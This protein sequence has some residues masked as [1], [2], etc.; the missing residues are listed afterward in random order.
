ML[1]ARRS[2]AGEGTTIVPPTTVVAPLTF[3]PTQA[4]RR[5]AHR[6]GVR[7]RPRRAWAGS[8]RPTTSSCALPDYHGQGAISPCTACRRSPHRRPVADCAR[9]PP[10][11]SSA[12]PI[13][14][15]VTPKGV[16]SLCTDFTSADGVL[17]AHAT[18]ISMSF[19]Y[20]HGISLVRRRPLRCRRPTRTPSPTPSWHRSVC[21]CGCAVRALENS[22]LKSD[23][24]TRCR[25]AA[26]DGRFPRSRRRRSAAGVARKRQPHAS[27]IRPRAI[28][29]V[30]TAERRPLR[31]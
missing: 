5:M 19:L 25:A 26:A 17:S 20:F 10:K 3:S 22:W 30:R 28:C 9:G 14:F 16:T 8:P 27:S 21:D 18:A 24:V 12:V 23:A 13:R 29:G 31:Y 7:G 11:C 2:R 6:A 15:E 4:Q 1:Y